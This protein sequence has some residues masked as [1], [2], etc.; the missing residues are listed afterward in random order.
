MGLLTG[1]SILSGVEIV[2]Y[3]LRLLPLIFS[4]ISGMNSIILV[5]SSGSSCLSGCPGLRW[6]LQRRKDL[7]IIWWQRHRQIFCPYS[8]TILRCL[9]VQCRIFN[10]QCSMLGIKRKDICCC[11]QIMNK[12]FSSSFIGSMMLK[13]IINMAFVYITH[14]APSIDQTSNPWQLHTEVTGAKSD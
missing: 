3:L 7:K 12:C 10:V 11:H 14:I 2:Y 13:F 1:F 4:A 9:T 8:W 5:F 6:S